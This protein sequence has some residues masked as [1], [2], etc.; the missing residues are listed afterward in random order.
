MKHLCNRHVWDKLQSWACGLHRYLHWYF[1]QIPVYAMQ[2]SAVTLLP[3][4]GVGQWVQRISTAFSTCSPFFGFVMKL[5]WVEFMLMFMFLQLLTIQGKQTWID[6][7]GQLKQFCCSLL[8]PEIVCIQSALEFLCRVQARNLSPNIWRQHHRVNGTSVAEH[9]TEVATLVVP[10]PY[11]GLCVNLNE[12]SIIRPAG[13]SKT[14]CK[15][16]K[17]YAT[18]MMIMMI[19]FFFFKYSM[20][21][22]RIQWQTASLLSKLNSCTVCEC[23]G[24][25]P[26]ILKD[27]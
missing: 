7:E 1:L 24:K 11:H 14:G 12:E 23:K 26:V 2:L 25:V 15:K 18:V 8:W 27:T 13:T 3:P 10:S 9:E 4:E 19:F 6:G 22:A 21:P 16:M 5:L 20:T 17:N